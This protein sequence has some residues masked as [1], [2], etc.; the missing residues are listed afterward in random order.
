MVYVASNDGMLHAFNGG[1][2]TDPNA[3]QEAW[4]II[5]REVLPRLNRLADTNWAQ[6]H[7]Y[8]VDATPTV[9][10][11]YDGTAW[12]TIMIAGLNKGGRAYY[13]VDITNPDSPV[14]L[15][16]FNTTNDPDLGY[17]F[18]NPVISKLED[19]RWVV[20]ATS[21]LN[22]VTPGDGKGYLYVLDAMTGSIIYKI[23]TGVGNTTT[24][25]GL[26]KIRNW[27]DNG[28]VDNTT[29]R[30]YGVDIQGHIWRFDVNNH[31]GNVAGP[32]S[33]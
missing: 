4:A 6:L 25:S 33:P 21:G 29:K 3:G 8:T 19:G 32:T 17:T 24:P 11:V 20:F 13:A 23:G 27:V 18:G 1:D 22:N 28:A 12:H 14:M 5:P 2:S 31:L 30:V 7:E 16:E 26:T 10:D 15:W 9:G